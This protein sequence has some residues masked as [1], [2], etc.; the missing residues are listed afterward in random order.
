[1]SHVI[2]TFHSE[3]DYYTGCQNVSHC[4]QHIYSGLHIHPSDHIPPNYETKLI[5][6][7]PQKFK[8][9]SVVR[10]LYIQNL[11]LNFR[12]HFVKIPS[13]GY[14]LHD[15][16]WNKVTCFLKKKTGL[17]YQLFS[18]LIHCFKNFHVALI[19]SCWQ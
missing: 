4:Q 5:L 18:F 7:A 19:P 3:D 8:F 16:K 17:K 14:I 11:I 13:K 10:C 1:M 2:T 9:T 15:H 12:I 6:L